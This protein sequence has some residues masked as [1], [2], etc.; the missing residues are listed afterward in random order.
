MGAILRLKHKHFDV[1]DDDRKSCIS[2]DGTTLH[3]RIRKLSN[4]DQGKPPEDMTTKPDIENTPQNT[5]L[6]YE[7]LQQLEQE[8]ASLPTTI[9]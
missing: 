9:Q 4:A 1:E 6:S 5:G 8:T 3:S 7:M 2:Y